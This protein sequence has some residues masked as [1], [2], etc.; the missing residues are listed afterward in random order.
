MFGTR[1]WSRSQK[2]L[3][4]GLLK[5][6]VIIYELQQNHSLHIDIFPIPLQVRPC[7]GVSTRRAAY[8]RICVRCAISSW[9]AHALLCLGIILGDPEPWFVLFPRTQGMS[10]AWGIA[11]KAGVTPPKLSFP[12]S[13]YHPHLLTGNLAVRADAEKGEYQELSFSLNQFS[14]GWRL[15][16]FSPRWCIVLKGIEGLWLTFY[17]DK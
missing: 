11:G 9:N 17:R 7:R 5:I 13:G 15:F 12:G 4:R 6:A 16:W 2:G 10:W 8:V 3:Q 14:W 1:N